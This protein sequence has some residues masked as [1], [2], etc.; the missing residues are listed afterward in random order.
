MGQHFKHEAKL[1]VRRYSKLREIAYF[2]EVACVKNGTL[3]GKGLNSGYVMD[4][5]PL[6][7]VRVRSNVH[8]PLG[9]PSHMV[10]KF[11]DS[12]ANACGQCRTIKNCKEQNGM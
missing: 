2:A 5:S 1:N 7:N 10:I 3:S 11:S 12:L 9:V 8:R 4:D 6:C